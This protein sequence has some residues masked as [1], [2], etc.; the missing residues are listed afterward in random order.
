MEMLG[1]IP[2]CIPSRREGGSCVRDIQRFWHTI[3]NI[4]IG[5]MALIA[6]AISY[7][8]N[9]QPDALYF[10]LVGVLTWIF[11]LGVF[12]SKPDDTIAHLSYLMSV[13]LMV[14]CSVNG[15]F[16]AV[17]R[18]WQ[19]KFVPLFQF[20]FTVFLPCLFFRCFAVF[21]SAKR[22][23]TNRFFKWWIYT[24][25]VLISAAIF[26]SYLSG[27]S[28]ERL[29]FLIDIGPRPL[30]VA[31]LLCLI[32]Y[33]LAGH[34]CLAHTWLF[35][36]TPRQRNQAKWLFWGIS[37][38]T[39]PVF[40]FHSLPS[41]LGLE[42]PYGRFSAYTLILIPTCYGVAILKYRL[43]DIELVLNRSSVY[44]LVSSIAL[45]VYLVSS[46]ILGEIF[47][48]ISPG[49]GRA[50]EILSIL[51]VVLLF[52]P[53]KER[54]QVFIDRHFDKRR[55]NYRQT[56]FNL[57]KTLSTI[58]RLDKLSE[59]LLNQLDE[60]LQPEF[61]ALLLKREY[62]TLLLESEYDVRSTGGDSGYSVYRQIGDREKL[63]E[64]LKE[65][66]LDSIVSGPERIS[67]KKLAVPLLSKGE[68]IG[69]ILLGGKLS[70]ADYNAEDIFLM[71]TVSHQTAI[72]IE[73]ALRQHEV[74]CIQAAKMES[75]RELVAGIA[76]K[77]SN[78]IG[79]ILCNNDVCRRAIGMIRKIVAEKH[80]R[81]MKEDRQLARALDALEKITQGSQDAS[82][83]IARIVT[84]LRQFVRL[85][86][87]TWQFANINE[88]IDSVITL[89]ESEFSDR[90][91]I[92]QDYGDVQSIYCSPSSLNQ[93]F[94]SMFRNACE[95]I[96]GE[97]SV[98]FSTSAQE[99]HVIVEISDTGTGIPAKDVDRIFDPGFT[100]KGVKVGVGLGLSVCWQIV[101]DEHGG[102]IGVSSNVGRGTTFT[103]T[104]PQG[105]QN[106]SM[107]G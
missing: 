12:I 18:G 6:V 38:G 56:L 29:L 90:I 103:I 79:T 101:V 65:L 10:Y 33:S 15:T 41:I 25:S 37:I 17:E 24:P 100:T 88:G 81:D 86:E 43:M 76:H 59:T 102:H 8:R 50:V 32:G 4:V 2:T 64:A 19:A 94:M 58:L 83:E 96:D 95:A 75:L 97:G 70:E 28:Y 99:E 60:V 27:N 51:V 92:S 63:R 98:H 71:R 82:G 57:S 91:N 44:A 13:G 22:F 85:D 80:L 106:L 72:S 61:A 47:S 48:G 14:I 74:Q 21:P 49:S 3:L 68:S 53:M 67:G 46:L 11:G 40:F 54:I 104:L 36:E 16:S 23:A 55:Y 52:A 105:Q 84:N 20:T 78:P 35:G 30:R 5:G 9:S 69:F 7:N 89:M 34:A 77:V 62:A 87:A 26:A 93:V 39:L 66:D 45:A 31:H 73:N 1:E 107:G 42:F